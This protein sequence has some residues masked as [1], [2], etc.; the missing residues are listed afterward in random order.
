MKNK[1]F[2]SVLLCLA[3]LAS[4]PV[5]PGGAAAA[6]GS[7]DNGMKI[8]KTATANSDGTYTITLEAYATGSQ[9]TTT[10]NKDIPT[11]IVLVVDQSGSMAEEIGSVSYKQYKAKESTNSEN[12]EKRHNGGSANLWHKLTDG[13][14]VSVSVTLQQKITYNKI[15]KGRNDNG[16]NGYTNYW[17]NRNNLYTYVNDEIKKVVYTRER[18][19]FVENYNC[20]YALE[21][22]TILNQNNEGAYHSPTFQNTDD[23]Y[24]YL[25][26]VDENQ[27]VYTYT[28]TDTTGAVQTIGT[29]TGANTRFEP[30]FYQRSTS[31][32][33]GGSRLNALK[34][35]ANAFASAVA[36]KAAGA[37]GDINTPADNVNHRIAVVG[38]ACGERYNYTNYNYKNTEVFVGRNQYAYGTA[39]QGQ[40][41]NAFQDM[42][43]STGVA[44][45]SASIGALDADGGT[46]T[47]LG[48]EMA[49]GIF[50]ETPIAEGEAR[51]RVIIVFTDG[52]PGWSGYESNIAT[53]AI[54]QAHTAKNTYGATVYSIGIFS[55]ADATSAGN[56][57]GSE[58]AKANWF[59]Q[60]VSSN[61]G[62]PR[63][64]SYYLSAGDSG[65]LSSI[66]QQISNNI[67]TG[68]SSTT[69]GSE[70]VVKDIIS[71]Y[72]T[73]PAGTTASDIRINTYDC[74]G[75]NGNTYT[76]S[77]TSGGDG[78]AS[79]TVNGDQVS[80]TGFNFSEN[81]CGTETSAQGTTTVRGKKL[82]ISF[83]V[84][85]KNGF[86]GGNDVITNASAGIYENGSAQTP[87]MTFEQPTVN[88]PIQD[89]TVTAQDKNVYL[90][91]E[92]TADELKNGAT[93]KVGNVELKLNES[94]YGLEAWQTAY[95]DITVVVKD[96]AGNVVD[97]KIA[98]LD[99]DTTYTI[100]VTVA[101]KNPGTTTPEK[102]T[103][104]TA[105]SD[106]GEGKIN[107]FKPELTF[108]DSKVEYKK[109]VLESSTPSYADMKA[110]FEAND[111]DGE[112]IWKHGDTKSTDVTMIDDKPA[113]T[114]AYSYSEN[115]IDANN[116]VQAITDIPVKVEVKI[117]T[118]YVTGNTTFK[119]QPCEPVCGWNNTEANGN[120]AFLLHVINVVGDLKIT[121]TGLNE[122]VYGGRED[123]ESAIFKVEGDNQ[124]WYVAINA[125]A[126]GTGSVTL[127][128]L[129]VGDYTVTE[130]TDWTWRYRSSTLTSPD[131][132]FST[133]TGNNTITVKV[134]GG[135]VTTVNCRNDSHN[136][137]WLGG[138][139]YAN[140][141][142]G[143]N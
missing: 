19:W 72:F 77:S 95:V 23:G 6:D 109:S 39:A 126:S 101:P 30:A 103:A 56:Q 130:L 31:T 137:K 74:T 88:V 2:L 99:D 42:N 122:K 25:A 38:F 114:L 138:D 52:V 102:G 78:G 84:D 11:D 13:S 121:K 81:W 33:G 58:T 104:A 59:M 67:T 96:A 60:Q 45:I 7:A 83:T 57:S 49:N 112:V 119:H 4:L 108:K 64:P 107:V 106:S 82:V 125:N 139:N 118:A 75:K 85:P 76:W 40:Y 110:Y 90:L 55:G 16:S 105:Q 91:G 142:F 29:S 73:L 135:A 27:N 18:D 113:L 62:T 124:T 48:L 54:A 36:A 3:L 87:V 79:A 133:G 32:S 123:Q 47:N 65:S 28:Y 5:L 89:V 22:G 8:S 86:L 14:Y 34:S 21:D 70:T 97:D 51:N 46:L 43:T 127:T 111:R 131:S 24:L 80:V 143:S 17:N 94:N 134:N 20:K 100:E 132:G 68:G 61:N 93:V 10:V 41:G 120:P 44:N 129:K 115:D 128:G 37:D 66:F 116:V 92:V 117:G 35:A 98:N 50:G 15:T 71:P 63:Y 136:D 12:Y 53:R 1:K 141:E 26:V 140:N 9:V 69:L